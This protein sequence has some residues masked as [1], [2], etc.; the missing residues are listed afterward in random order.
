MIL[1]LPYIES[2]IEPGI[3]Y[4]G[5][6]LLH[7]TN[8]LRFETLEVSVDGTEAI[9]EVQRRK[10]DGQRRRISS[11]DPVRSTDRTALLAVP[12]ARE[13]TERTR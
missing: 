4:P 1:R 11:E 2:V 8:G 9:V 7:P 5:G 6:D 10:M 3:R 13:E 12:G